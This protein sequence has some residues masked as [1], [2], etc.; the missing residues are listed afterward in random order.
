MPSVRPQSRAEVSSSRVPRSCTFISPIAMNPNAPSFVPHARLRES[1]TPRARPL[2]ISKPKAKPARPNGTAT[3]YNPP[4]TLLQPTI[5]RLNSA[6]VEA[7]QRL[8]QSLLSTRSESVTPRPTPPSALAH[9]PPTRPH[10]APMATPAP[11]PPPTPFNEPPP[12]LLALFSAI[13]DARATA[14]PST[15]TPVPASSA[16]SAQL[17]SALAR[18]ETRLSQMIAQRLEGEAQARRGTP[19][20]E[21]HLFESSRW[22]KVHAE[23]L[24]L[25][26]DVYEDPSD[27]MRSVFERRLT[28]QLCM[29]MPGEAGEKTRSELEKST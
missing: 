3:L 27:E 21:V 5:P 20:W 19:V 22:W 18:V 8:L 7:R 1:V 2:S 4:E 10:L 11:E 9:V 6:T 24:R 16:S 26:H 14:P 15:P 28:W 23:L 25:S 12:A 13:Q 17:L 29:N